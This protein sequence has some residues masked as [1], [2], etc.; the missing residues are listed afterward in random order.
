MTNVKHNDIKHEIKHYDIKN[1]DTKQNYIQHNNTKHYDI[2]HKENSAPTVI[3]AQYSFFA[4]MLKPS[5]RML[6][7]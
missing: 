3:Y 5:S 6:L 7:W 1:N 2:L 4:K